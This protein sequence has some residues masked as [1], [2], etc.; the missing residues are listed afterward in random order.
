[1]NAWEM[2]TNR[3]DWSDLFREIARALGIADAKLEGQD[4]F[5]GRPAYHS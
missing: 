5:M 2:L 4:A 1:M 3:S